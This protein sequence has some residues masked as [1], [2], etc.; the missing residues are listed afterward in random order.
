M[1]CWLSL[2]VLMSSFVFILAHQLF[3]KVM[4]NVLWYYDFKQQSAKKFVFVLVS[5]FF[6]SLFIFDSSCLVFLFLSKR[7]M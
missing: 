5:V 1:L 4:T 3:S 6:L 7:I 2:L